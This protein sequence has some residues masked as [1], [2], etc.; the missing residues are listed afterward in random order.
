MYWVSPCHEAASGGCTD[1]GDI[2]IVQY[3]AFVGKAI[4]VGCFDFRTMESN[5]IPALQEYKFKI[6][7]FCTD[8]MKSGNNVSISFY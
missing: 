7:T 4:D 5:I 1:R 3:H 6:L 2:V 8:K